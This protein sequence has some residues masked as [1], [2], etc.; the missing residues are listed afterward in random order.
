MHPAILKTFRAT[1]LL[2]AT[3]L[4]GAA[5][6]PNV[7]VILTDDLGYSDLGCYGSEIETPTLDRLAARGLRFSNFY[8]TGKCHSSRVSLLTGRWCRQAGDEP[9]TH[10][11]TL[12]E[13]LRPTG[14]F[15]AIS[16]KWHLAKTPEDYGFDRF[17]GHLSGAT[18]FF[19]G[20]KTFRLNGQPWEVPAE[21]FYTT[22]AKVDFALKFLA[23]ARRDE[24]PWFLYLPFNAPHAPIHPLPQDYEKYR[25]RYDSGWDA[26][27]QKRTAKLRKEGLLPQTATPSPRPDHI[28]AWDS[29]TP[30]I[31]DWEA[32]RMAGYAAMIDRVDQ[33]LA[34]LVADLESAKELENTLIVFLSDNGACP[35][36][37]QNVRP[38]L[39]PHDPRSR[40]SDSTGWAWARNAPFR[41]YKQ[42][43]FEGGIA[44]PAIFHWPAG[45]KSKPGAIDP[46]P[47]HLVDILPTV[48][49]ITQTPELKSL[50]GRTP[51]PLAGVSLAPIFAG[52]PLESRPPIHFLFGNDRAL[53]DG[54]WKLVSFRGGPWELYHLSADP[55]ELTNLA[56]G[57]PDRVKRMAAEW[58]R[59][60]RDVLKAPASEQKPVAPAKSQIH[61]EWSDYSGERG[62]N[63]TRRRR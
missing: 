4:T 26:V 24:K 5:A 45:L 35:Y 2:L 37:R 48:L 20:D 13:M 49:E 43:Q 27:H 57:Q 40:W 9:M 36:D 10:A 47:A 14:Y 32:R 28:P 56:A 33:E 38:D 53:R 18:H 25:N 46:T 12:P 29:L 34:R 21:G 16:G 23:E 61:P 58:H 42:N 41:F 39:P 51:S 19:K 44:T 55:T 54:D 17:F 8:N 6:R 60:T 30:E 3:C 59:M 50:P 7:L 31:R 62:A 22:T 63:T 52:K 11:V 1:A 15:T